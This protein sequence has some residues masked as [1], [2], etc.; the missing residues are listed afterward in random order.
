MHR[1]LRYILSVCFLLSGLLKILGLHAFEQEVQLYGDAY[2]GEWVH[3]ISFEIA[4]AVCVVEIVSAITLIS[5]VF[6]KITAFVYV[7][8]LLIFVYLTGTNLLFPS[9][10]GRI[11]SC[12]CFGELIHFG[13]LA[14]FIKSVIIF[15]MAIAN[16]WFVMCHKSSDKQDE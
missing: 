5:G 6:P 9:V 16:L 14:S 8:M 10:M 2:I 13:P 12:G 7:A 11:E 1:I 15:I 3:D 4:I